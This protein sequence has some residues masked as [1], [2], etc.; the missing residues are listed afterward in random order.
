MGSFYSYQ[1]QDISFPEETEEER[2]VF[3]LISPWAEAAIASEIT[4]S[5]PPES[6]ESC[7]PAIIPTD[8]KLQLQQQGLQDILSISWTPNTSIEHVTLIRNTPH[9]EELSLGNTHVFDQHIL[10]TGKTH[11]FTLIFYGGCGYGQYADPIEYLYM[12]EETTS[13]L[14]L[15]WKDEILS[16]L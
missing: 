9:I 15:I 14:Q 1:N 6:K 10:V 5:P 7:S 11:R 12:P 8:I 4:S 3:P 2:G 16:V 13:A